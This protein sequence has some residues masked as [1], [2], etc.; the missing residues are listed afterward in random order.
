LKR[1]SVNEDLCHI[2]R[3][4]YLGFDFV[5]NDILSLGKLEDVLL[6]I[7]NFQATS[8]SELANISSVH[9]TIAVNSGLCNIRLSVIPLEAVIASIA[10]LTSRSGSALMISIFRRVIHFRDIYKLNIKRR[11][12]STN[13]TTFW[14]NSP[15]NRSWGNTLSLPIAF[16]NS[17]TESNFKKI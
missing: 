16:M 11:H 17:N 9:P 13:M 8:L 10:Y 7:N 2:G 5:W 12:R 15:C 6:A 4:S 3:L 1:V 14:V